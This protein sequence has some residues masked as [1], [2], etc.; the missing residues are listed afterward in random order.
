[1]RASLRAPASNLQDEYTRYCQVGAVEE[2][3]KELGGFLG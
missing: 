2:W 3:S 1:M